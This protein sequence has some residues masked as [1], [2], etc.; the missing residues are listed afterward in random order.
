MFQIGSQSAVRDASLEGVE[1]LRVEYFRKMLAGLKLKTRISWNEEGGYLMDILYP[2]WIWDSGIQVLVAETWREPTWVNRI[3]PLTQMVL[4]YLYRHALELALCDLNISLYVDQQIRDAVSCFPSGLAYAL[5][6]FPVQHLDDDYDKHIIWVV[7]QTPLDEQ[8][9]EIARFRWPGADIRP[10]DP[11]KYP[12]IQK[13][14]NFY[15]QKY[16]T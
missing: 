15:L 10:A 11:Q 5:P 1:R 12:Q 7:T 13:Y 16:F 8:M 3:D 6:A 4:V 2:G 9:L 14:L